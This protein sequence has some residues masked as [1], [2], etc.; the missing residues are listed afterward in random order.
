MYLK[1]QQHSGKPRLFQDLSR[2]EKRLFSYEELFDN[3]SY[4]KKYILLVTIIITICEIVKFVV[5]PL[6]ELDPS[7]R[8]QLYCFPIL[9]GVGLAF[10][11]I[12]HL[13]FCQKKIKRI[14]ITRL[15]ILGFA[16]AC[17]CVGVFLNVYFFLKLA[18]TNHTHKT[19]F[20]AITYVSDGVFMTILSS[21]VH[22]FWQMKATVPIAY[23]LGVFVGYLHSGEDDK[24]GL[25]IA[26]LL[27]TSFYSVS[28]FAITEYFRY[29]QF[30]KKCEGDD[31]RMIQGCILDR[32]NNAI[33]V[34][35]PSGNV[36][37]SNKEFRK[38]SK[39][40]A[41]KFFT[42]MRN[43]K[44]R[45]DENADQDLSYLNSGLPKDS[46]EE[47]H[48]NFLGS[49]RSSKPGLQRKPVDEIVDV[50][51]LIQIA[52]QSIKAGILTDG[53]YFTF[54]GKLIEDDPDEIKQQRSYE[55]AVSPM[56][57]CSKVILIFHDTTQHARM[58]ALETNNHYKDKLLASVSHELRTPL[59]GNLA[60]IET[61]LNH[62]DIPQAVKE[63]LL[64]PAYRS[65]KLLGYLINDILDYSQIKAEKLRMVFKELSLKKTL[66]SCY[67]LLEIQAKAKHL[68]L[69]FDIDENIPE[70]FVTDHDRVVQVVLNLLSNALKFTFKGKITLKAKYV[71]DCA[72]DNYVEIQVEDTGIGI[73]P[74]DTS[75]LF[76]EFTQIGGEDEIKSLNSKGVGL[77]LTIAD[78]LA[79]RLSSS[80]LQ[81]ISVKST[82]G[83]GSCFSFQL[84]PKSLQVKTLFL[85]PPS[86]ILPN[87]IRTTSQDDSSEGSDILDQVEEY[88]QQ[89]PRKKRGI[90]AR[91]SKVPSFNYLPS[92]H[93][94]T[95]ETI[96]AHRNLKTL[97]ALAV[98]SHPQKKGTILIVDDEPFNI[99]ALQSM[100]KNYEFEIESVFNGK[101]AVD[102][103]TE[104]YKYGSE[105]DSKYELIF[106]DCQ[107]PIMDGY[108]ATKV[109]CEIM[110]DKPTQIPIIGCTAFT[111]Q[112]KMDD[113]ITSGMKDVINKP[114]T[115]KGLDEILRKYTALKESE[116]RKP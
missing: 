82:F 2:Y 20:D 38:I 39:E 41:K 12:A 8:A 70:D 37:Y 56:C 71:N 24:L 4:M 80:L 26:Q 9:I 96:S 91:R 54:D 66:M 76:Q 17:I 53:T 45:V 61:T 92:P 109:L 83:Q 55:I 107:M 36:V 18:N 95:P 113:C 103:V 35:E 77:G 16:N 63:E 75:K 108:E 5:N 90:F 11:F 10:C 98:S 104:R 111:A 106:M 102:K 31:W 42:K 44:K 58:V 46:I 49:T 115:R 85:K 14:V 64:V 87:K 59:N 51:E 22:P 84:E 32:V 97:P 27:T 116:K 23:Y 50:N 89:T 74:E 101:E 73:K 78:Q 62:E 33:V 40:D 25:A 34:V 100:L 7:E 110:K 28:L 60:L 93:L 21:M 86:I 29:Q 68:D 69:I 43:L 52:N 19:W 15:V 47:S 30:L 48:T 13:K 6:G 72:Y 114:V 99:L 88:T 79:R 94:E 81:G 57:S 1:I 112:S 105:D 67:Q 65:G 3:H